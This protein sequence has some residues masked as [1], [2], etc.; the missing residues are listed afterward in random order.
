MPAEQEVME[1]QGRPAWGPDQRFLV[2]VP[3]R[4]AVATLAP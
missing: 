1:I 2:E 4:F 3:E